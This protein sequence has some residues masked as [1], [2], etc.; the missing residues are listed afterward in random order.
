M[1]LERAYMLLL[2]IKEVGLHGGAYKSLGTI[3]EAELK[4]LNEEATEEVKATAKAE[5]K[6]RATVE[7]KEF[8]AEQHR[9]ELEEAPKGYLEQQIEDEQ[10]KRDTRMFSSDPRTIKTPAEI[11]RRKV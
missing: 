9:L 2:T 5:A 6:R 7:A 10:M 1:N 11:E 3:A 4:T 8:D